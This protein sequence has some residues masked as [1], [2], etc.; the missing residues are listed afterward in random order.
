MATDVTIIAV[1]AG[2]GL[3]AGAAGHAVAVA[4]AVAPYLLLAG[5]LASR[6]PARQIRANR[7]LPENTG[8]S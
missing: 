5:R 4:V 3:V 7:S 1:Y 6:G 8:V 2:Y